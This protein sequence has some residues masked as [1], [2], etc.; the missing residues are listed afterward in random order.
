MCRLRR[1]T[2]PDPFTHLSSVTRGTARE[3]ENDY[4]VYNWEYSS[5]NMHIPSTYTHTHTL[6]VEAVCLR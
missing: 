6:L 2:D 5:K 3:R 1:H 4:K